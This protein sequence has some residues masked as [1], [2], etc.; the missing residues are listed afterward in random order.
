MGSV[1]KPRGGAASPPAT[2]CHVTT[3]HVP[4]D[5]R[6]FHKECRSLADAGYDVHL[7][8]CHDRDEVVDGIRVH[9]LP[10]PPGRR[11]RVLLWPWLA[12]AKVLSL[13]PAPSLVHFHDPELLPASQSLRLCGLKAIYDVHENVAGDLAAKPYL[14]RWLRLPVAMIYRAI[15]AVLGIGMPTLHVLEDIAGQYRQPRSVVRNLP[16]AADAPVRPDR[17]VGRPAK[18]VY[19]GV[20]STDRGAGT[21][22]DLAGELNCRALD[23][24]LRI[25]G[26]I[27]EPGLA[28]ALAGAIVD[29]GLADRVFVLGRMP[30][31]MARAALA[32]AD[33][34]LCLLQPTTNYRRSLPTKV[35]DYMAAGLPVVA[36]DIPGW[37]TYVTEPGS[38]LQVDPADTAGAA[39]CVESILKDPARFRAMSR[40]GRAAVESTFCWEIEQQKLL[41]F[42]DRLLASRITP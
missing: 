31:A 4:F 24:E 5:T 42:Y 29:H 39:D 26:P 34:G 7:V 22:I 28:E 30:Y 2:V 25:I 16:W 38:G 13:R 18:L 37:R 14:P 19:L 20:V 6:I 9:A 8:A 1:E 12:C 41:A 27:H 36:T 21:M 32:E 11:A 17:P 10:R 33:L 15:E 40:R 23:F 35:L 3:V